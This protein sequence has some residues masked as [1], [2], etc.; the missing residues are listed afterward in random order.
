V[1]ELR[2]SAHATLSKT[3][4]GILT[5]RTRRQSKE[6]RPGV[7]RVSSPPHAWRFSHHVTP[8]E[9]AAVR[10]VS[11]LMRT[12][13]R[14]THGSHD[15][16]LPLEEVVADRTGRARAWGIASE[17]DEFLLFGRVSTAPHAGTTGHPRL[18]SSAPSSTRP[19]E[20]PMVVACSPC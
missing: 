13:S 14:V 6:S 20:N 7:E 8:V 17:V 12:S 16:R 2:P 18:T 9:R 19:D 15:R 11:E 10:F 5:G 3:Q 4:V 1:R